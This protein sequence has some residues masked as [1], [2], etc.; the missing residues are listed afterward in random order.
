MKLLVCADDTLQVSQ[1]RDVLQE[2]LKN[3]FLGFE[4][5]FECSEVFAAETRT[6]SKKE[7]RIYIFPDT[8]R[9]LDELPQRLQRI[10]KAL[11]EELRLNE[12]Q[13]ICPTVFH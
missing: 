9:K 3:M 12:S 2:L 6:G 13:V 8:D 10:A 4:C 1:A 11:A 5:S 7:V